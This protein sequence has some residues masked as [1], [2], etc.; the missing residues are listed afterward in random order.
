MKIQKFYPYILILLSA[1]GLLASAILTNDAILLAKNPEAD[2]PCNINPFLSCTSVAKVWQSSVFGF[3]NAILGTIA[4]SL[5]FFFFLAL[6]L[7]TI[8][9][10]SL[11]EKVFGVNKHR[12]IFWSLVNVGTLASVIFAIWFAYESIFVLRTLCI[13]CMV[14]W[15]VTWPIFLYTTI[16]NIKESHFSLNKIHKNFDS[17]LI[18]NHKEILL[19][20]Y[21][22]IVSTILIQ[23]RDFFIY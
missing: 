12:K 8:E 20:W 11:A 9:R 23:F 15:S 18:K 13:Y 19:T 14:V 21:I 17:I 6:L 1:V 22:I 2:L 16:W 7:N 4:F 10:E 5:L 3:P